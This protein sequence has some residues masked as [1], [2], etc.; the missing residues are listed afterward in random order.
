[1]SVIFGPNTPRVLQFLTHI[2]DLSAEEIDRVA[3]LWDQ[4]PS[5]ARA[6][7]WSAIRRTTSGDER[8]GVLAAAS[9]ARLTALAVA[10]QRRRQDRAFCAAAWDAAAGVAVGYRI[11]ARHDTLVGPFAVIMPAVALTPRDEPGSRRPHDPGF[12]AGLPP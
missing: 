1:M 7:A 3:N 12:G 9:V 11:G 2:E 10:R 5:R 6:E 8:H 4:T